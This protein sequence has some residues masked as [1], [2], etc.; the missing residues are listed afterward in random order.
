MPGVRRTSLVLICSAVCWGLGAQEIED[1]LFFTGAGSEEE[2]TSDDVAEYSSLRFNING[3]HSETSRMFFSEYQI[4]ALEDYISRHGALLSSGEL[5]AVGC[6]SD[7]FISHL[8][9]FIYFEDYGGDRQ[10]RLSHE[11]SSQAGDKLTLEGKI[12]NQS[13]YSLRYALDWG[14]RGGVVVSA[15][16]GYSG[17][18]WASGSG[19]GSAGGG[20]VGVALA[21]L[22]DVH[23]SGSWSS[24]DGRFRV[25]AGDFKARFGQGLAAYDGLSFDSVYTIAALEK[26]SNGIRPASS[27]SGSGSKTGVAVE[28]RFGRYRRIGVSVWSYTPWLRDGLFS[29]TS[30]ARVV[31]RARGFTLGATGVWDYRQDSGAGSAGRG[32]HGGKVA[33]DIAGSFGSSFYLWGEACYQP[34]KGVLEGV[35]GCKYS[36]WYG[37]TPGVRILLQQ[38]NIQGNVVA[39]GLPSRSVKITGSGAYIIKKSTVSAKGN[40]ECTWKKGMWDGKARV[41]YTCSGERMDGKLAFYKSLT[42][43]VVGKCEAYV[44]WRSARLGGGLQGNVCL[45]GG[46]SSGGSGRGGGSGGGLS[47]GVMPYLLGGFECKRVKLTAQAAAWHAPKWDNRLWLY[48]YD[49]PESFTVPTLYKEGILG[50]IFVSAKL[51]EPRRSALKLYGRLAATYYLKQKLT[52]EAKFGLNYSF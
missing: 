43:K 13:L 31:W 5:R 49:L 19:A 38:G 12:T 2:L 36:G 7:E 25:V 17:A 40:V 44:K 33:V 32:S 4:A 1:I 50:N 27:F 52:L 11:I 14:D 26:R 16:K 51:G 10:K 9:P 39:E 42:H 28:G 3:P 22:P 41:Y 29:L 18:S 6:F 24:R 46:A 48:L 30:G 20:A 45:S 35:A 47:L 21:W 15:H 23:L 34:A 37:F 8:I